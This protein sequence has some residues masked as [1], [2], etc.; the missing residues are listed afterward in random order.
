MKVFLASLGALLCGILLGWRPALPAEDGGEVISRS[1]RTL[2]LAGAPL[3]QVDEE[4][5]VSWRERIA[6]AGSTKELVALYDEILQL[7]GGRERT[8]VSV[9]LQG[10][11]AEVDPVGAMEFFKHR[12]QWEWRAGIL[13]E[14]VRRDFEAG[15]A[16]FEWVDETQLEWTERVVMTELLK[17]EELDLGLRF[18][19]MTG[20]FE[21]TYDLDWRSV[22]TKLAKERTEELA[23]IVEGFLGKAEASTMES[24]VGI[25]AGVMAEDDPAVAIAWSRRLPGET[26]YKALCGALY[27]WGQ[28]DPKAVIS[29]LVEWAKSGTGPEERVRM[30]LEAFVKYGLI[31]SLVN[32]DFGTAVQ[33]QVKVGGDAGRLGE[34]AAG[35][36]RAGELSLAEIYGEVAGAEGAF[37]YQLGGFFKEFWEGAGRRSLDE[38]WT[39]LR[40]E[41]EG[42]VRST[43][44][45][46]LWEN[47]LSNRPREAAQMISAMAAGPE[48]DE[49]V[50]TLFGKGDERGFYVDFLK[51]LPLEARAV[52]LSVLYGKPERERVAGESPFY[53]GAVVEGLSKVNDARLREEVMARVGMHWGGIDPAGALTWVEQLAGEDR[54]IATREVARGWA[55]ADASGLAASLGE[56][57]EGASKDLLIAGLTEE[58]T[59]DD[60][61]GAWLWGGTI[62]EQKLG[63]EA[64][65]R[66]FEAWVQSDETAARSALE[67]AEI[68]TNEREALRAIL[69]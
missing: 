44:M 27:S 29:Q 53:P 39:F 46:K 69:K 20:S 37:Q 61:E 59:K 26:Q 13:C 52:G 2:K 45:A 54:V 56:R 9:I 38:A 41:P 17:R 10:R 64:R 16:G 42:E 68:G 66:A 21:P 7:E 30:K 25:L 1:D 19:R 24:V 67:S 36:W 8:G 5:W 43:A 3:L 60:P 32:H 62:G 63:E 6:K 55:A 47:A 15:L 58:L 11:W 40:G 49:L 65:A 48:R 57:S 14:W 51:A 12:D 50:K 33:W 4:A 18:L 22:W 35:R 31:E 23:A 34:T 28:R